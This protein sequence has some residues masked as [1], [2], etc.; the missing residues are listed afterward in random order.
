MGGSKSIKVNFLSTDEILEIVS[1]C[2]SYRSVLFNRYMDLLIGYLT[3]GDSGTD[4]LGRYIQVVSSLIFSADNVIL[5][6]LPD[7][8]KEFSQAEYKVVELLRKRLGDDFWAEGL[9]ELFYECARWGELFGLIGVIVVPRVHGNKAYIVYPWDVLFYYPELPIDDDS[10]CIVRVIKM[11]RREAVKRFGEEVANEAQ[12]SKSVPNV[13]SEFLRRVEVTNSELDVEPGIDLKSDILSRYLLFGGSENLVE[14]YEVWYK[15]LDS[16]SV[17]QAIVVGDHVVAHSVSPYLDDDYPF[18]FYVSEPVV[19]SVY[20]RGA[21]EK[22]IALQEKVDEWMKKFETACDLLSNPPLLIQTYS[23][24]ID[25][26]DIIKNIATPGGVV[27][28]DSPDMK[29]EHY[30]PRVDLQSIAVIL[31]KYERNLLETVGLN[32]ITLGSNVKG[33]RS[34]SH[35]QLIAMFAGNH[36]KSKALRFE[37]FI[38]RVLTLWCRYLIRHTKNYQITT[39][40][41][42]DV[43]AHTTSPIVAMN[44]QEVLLSLS[45]S[46]VIP[47]DI[48]I[49]LL[50]IPLKWKVKE[51]MQNMVAAKMVENIDA[52]NKEKQK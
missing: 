7:E 39:P 18:A 41:K 33:V 43:F 47:P 31:E 37:Q 27:I 24:V 29:V 52:Q 48:L 36:I 46:G 9:D 30:V 25:R 26:E 44:Y 15:D 51:Y 28:V 42:V 10:Q 32:D 35:A 23:G 20:G 21:G 5:D 1:R 12:V 16:K 2:L 45:E 34:A 6:I 49:E 17:C 8:G 50:P 14:V 40:I 19:G 4:I 3:C 13:L 22:G 38:E 11:G